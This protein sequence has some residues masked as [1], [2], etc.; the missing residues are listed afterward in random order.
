MMK[1]ISLALAAAMFASVSALAAPPAA[2]ARIRG[3]ITSVDAGKIVV[4]TAAGDDL[5][6]ALTANTKYLGVINSSLDKIEQ[7]SYIGTAT[8]SVGPTQVALEVVVFP[9]AMKGVGEGHYAWDKL[10]DTTLSGHSS[11]SSAMTN[12]TVASVS[13]PAGASVNSAMTNGNV[14]AASAQNGVKKLTVSYK[15]GEQSIIVPPTAPIVTFRPG[16]T[17]DVTKGAS[18][19]VEAVKND[20][21]ESAVLVAVG[22][23]GVK[24]PM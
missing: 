18:V 17:A 2:P 21:Q 4:H 12:G 9:A 22:V 10:P 5:P 24:P 1:R 8:K 23:D 16:S 14:S 6:I 13:A 19:F 7:G 11:T 20:G 15:G 3:T